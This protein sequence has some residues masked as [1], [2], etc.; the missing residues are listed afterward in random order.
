MG[1]Q[2]D[3]DVAREAAEADWGYCNPMKAKLAREAHSSAVQTLIG[4]GYTH[5]EAEKLIRDQEDQ[6]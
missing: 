4:R 1:Y 6:E 2:S 3:K 5:S